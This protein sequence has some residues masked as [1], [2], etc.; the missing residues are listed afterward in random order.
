M[1]ATFVLYGKNPGGRM[2]PPPPPLNPGGLV[3]L[4]P[5][6]GGLNAG[7]RDG[8]G[9]LGGLGLYMGGGGSDGRYKAWLYHLHDGVM[10]LSSQ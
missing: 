4:S 7:G 3:G 5:K 9:G 10:L 2:L 8:I 1:H 6:P